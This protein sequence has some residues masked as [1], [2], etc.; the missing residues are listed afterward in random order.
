MLGEGGMA[1]VYRAIQRGFDR[2]VA[3]KIISST[4]AAEKEFG[5]RFI[6]EAK[7]V[8]GL[9]NAHIVPVYD[10]GEHDGVYY[11]AMEL[12]S[13]GDLRA[14]ID[15]G[16]DHKSALDIIYQLAQ[17]LKYA[18]AGGF[19]HRDVKPDNVLFRDSSTAVLTDFG[20]ARTTDDS[21]DHTQITQVSSVIGSPA[22][23]SPEQALGKPLDARSDI[24]S[25]GILLYEMLTGDLPFKGSNVAEISLQ[26]A[27]DNVPALPLEL[28]PL[29]DFVSRMLAYDRN[30][31]VSS[32]DEVLEFIAT[33][34]AREGEYS[35]VAID[36]NATLAAPIA[37]ATTTQAI[38][39]SRSRY[40]PAAIA[41][42]LIV[43]GTSAYLAKDSFITFFNPDDSDAAIVQPGLAGT[44]INQEQHSQQGTGVE[45]A[46]GDRDS[47]IQGG[48]T[49][50]SETTASDLAV[51]DDVNPPGADEFFAFTEAVTSPDSNDALKFMERFPQG[52]L[53]DIVRTKVSGDSETVADL[54]SRAQAGDARAQFVL[55]ELYDTGWVVEQD[56]SRALSLASQS[57]NSLSPFSQYHYAMLLLAENASDAQKRD[58]L[59]MLEASAQQG[60]F[61]AQTVLANYLFEGR[62]VGRDEPKSLRLLELA[63]AQGD[64]NALFNLGRI[65]DSG[66]GNQP[67]QPDVARGYFERAKALGHPNA[68]NF[69][70]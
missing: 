55:S 64:R 33:L 16:L 56:R 14:R 20:I 3:L 36:P 5:R 23:M 13:G 6:R 39:T 17:A 18:H 61:L 21:A 30:N 50:D 46:P 27:Q 41:A 32:C 62:L 45:T 15:A 31:R 1:R 26:H 70:Q 65:F 52:V 60:F 11:L 43:A 42:V 69:L 8:G 37:A 25:L 51:T 49:P 54:T 24:F 59:Q 40:R 58:G 48:S 29:Q 47:I 12:L 68:A 67:P 9:S 7:I 38:P 10:V 57:A 22:Y 28:Q 35:K 44:G 2:P 4:L 63:G 53:A 19:I 34:T 66:L